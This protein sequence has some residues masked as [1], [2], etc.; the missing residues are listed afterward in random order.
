[1]TSA[2]GGHSEGA[3]SASTGYAAHSEGAG[4]VSN[5]FASHTDGWSTIANGMAQHVFGQWNAE[6]ISPS[7]QYDN[8]TYVEIVGN[9]SSDSARSNARTL[10]W[11]GNEILAGKLTVG[12]APTNDMDVATK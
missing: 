11:S 2:Q 8:G 10:D 4:T 9:G 7:S 3:R 12:A 1:M 5:G 6:D